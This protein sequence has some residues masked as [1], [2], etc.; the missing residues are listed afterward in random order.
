MISVR[1]RRV[2]SSWSKGRSMKSRSFNSLRRKKVKIKRT[3]LI[4][5]ELLKRES[6]ILN[7]NSRA[8]VSLP[9]L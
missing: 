9:R 8:S 1:K 4:Q 7:R 5:T 2:I 6:L 3:E